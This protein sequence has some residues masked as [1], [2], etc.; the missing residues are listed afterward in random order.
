METLTA[1]QIT[2]KA[3]KLGSLLAIFSSRQPLVEPKSR[4]PQATFASGNL[5]VIHLFQIVDQSR[6]GR[7]PSE[8]FPGYGA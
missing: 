3:A 8:F 2:R 1:V 5:L 6:P 4:S 7:I